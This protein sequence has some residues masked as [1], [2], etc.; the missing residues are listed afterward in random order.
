M[1]TLHVV[2]TLTFGQMGALIRDRHVSLNNGEMFFGPDTEFIGK[3]L[4]ERLGSAGYV[5]GVRA[6][7]NKAS[8]AAITSIDPVSAQYGHVILEARAD[9]DDALRFKVTD[10]A[11]VAEALEYGLD[12]EDIIERL[13][14]AASATFEDDTLAVEIVC[15]PAVNLD[16]QIMVTTVSG[17]L[18]F[19]VDGVTFVKVV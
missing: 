18:N 9:A 7:L 4:C 8:V 15:F 13:E 12:D 6:R 17:D 11:L 5:M 10:L 3:F 1:E 16:G 14:E 2:T 19:D